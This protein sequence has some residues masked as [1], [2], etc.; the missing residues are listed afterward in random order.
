MG[1]V[2][3]HLGKAGGQVG[4][5]FFD[6]VFSDRLLQGLFRIEGQDLD[7]MLTCVPQDLL[8]IGEGVAPVQGPEST[9]TLLI[10]LSPDVRIQVGLRIPGQHLEPEGQVFGDLS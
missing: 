8:V 4:F 10:H 7:P 2:Q 1:V 6:R 5:D 9:K 3:V